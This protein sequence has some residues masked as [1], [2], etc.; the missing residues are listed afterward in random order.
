M[1]PAANRPLA[2]DDTGR[3]VRPALT[4]EYIVRTALAILD[5][6]GAAGLSMRKLGAELGTNPMAFYHHLPNKSALFDGVIEAAYAEIDID[7]DGLA[8]TGGWR[9]LLAAFAR[10][11]REV[12]RRH[13]HV[14]PLVA[15][16]PAYSPAVLGLADRALGALGR[17]GFADRELL[18]MVNA[19]RSFTIGHVLAEVGDPVGGPV[20]TE[21][22]AAELLGP[23]PNLARATA[24]GYRPQEQFEQGLRALLDGFERWPRQAVSKPV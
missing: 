14:V 23:Y 16:R 10:S 3:P 6:D 9:D 7:I 13:P 19:L 8:R 24:G 2:T 15:T 17:S 12:L 18:V 22:E 21:Q 20:A 1:P 5:R 4:R 11:L